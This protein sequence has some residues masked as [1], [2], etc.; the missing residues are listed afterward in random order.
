MAAETQYTAN[1]G[2]VKISTANSNLDGTGTL[3]TVITGASNGTLIK[4]VIIKATD[5]GS[6]STSQGMVRLFIYD[7]SSTLLLKEVDIP[8]MGQSSTDATF[9]TVIPLN[10][11]LES[12]HVLKASTQNATGFNVIAEGLDFAYYASSVRPESTNYTANTG[13]ATITTQNTALDGSGTLAT[14]VTAGASGSG[15][16]GLAINSISLKAYTDVTRGMLRLFIQ[17]TG[18]GASNTFLFTEIPLFPVDASATFQSYHWVIPFLSTLQIQAGYK[19][20][21]TIESTAGQNVSGVVDA[22]DWK[23]PA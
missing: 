15:W 4:N 3:G 16:K 17:N 1:T 14:L 21:A 5:T 18:T 12:G 9:E 10:F 23:Y 2:L 6:G 19:I 13:A 11:K 7:G 8:A 22:M 20:C